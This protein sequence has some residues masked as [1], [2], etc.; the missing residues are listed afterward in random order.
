M[1]TYIHRRI[2]K[3]HLGAHTSTELTKTTNKTL[4]NTL[5]YINARKCSSCTQIH[6][7]TAH[8]CTCTFTHECARNILCPKRLKRLRRCMYVFLY[9]CMY[10]SMYE[11]QLSRVR[12]LRHPDMYKCVQ[13]RSIACMYLCLHVRILSIP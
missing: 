9:V 3:L 7:T 11:V 4:K 1:H 13:V 10:E 5:L 12:S 2:Y 6:S 8:I